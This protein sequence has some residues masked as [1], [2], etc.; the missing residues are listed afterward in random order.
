MEQLLDYA[1][2]IVLLPLLSAALIAVFGRLMPLKGSE[3]G[4]ATMFVC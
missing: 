3:L 1:W 4:I 2:V